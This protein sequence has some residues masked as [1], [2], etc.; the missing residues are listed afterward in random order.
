MP[1]DGRCFFWGLL[2]DS[3]SEEEKTEWRLAERG[4]G[5]PVDASRKHQEDRGLLNIKLLDFSTCRDRLGTIDLVVVQDPAQEQRLQAFV[6]SK[7]NL[8]TQCKT[9]FLNS[10]TP[11]A[12]PAN[13]G[14]GT[15][16]MKRAKMRTCKKLLPMGVSLLVPRKLWQ[17]LSLRFTASSDSIKK[18]SETLMLSTREHPRK[19][20]MLLMVDHLS[21]QDSASLS[22]AGQQAVTDLLF[23]RGDL[24]LMGV[25]F[26]HHA[27]T[28]SELTVEEVIEMRRIH[29][30][31]GS[32]AAS[33]PN[34]SSQTLENQNPLKLA[35][36]SDIFSFLQKLSLAR[37]TRS[38]PVS[39]WIQDALV[40]AGIRTVK[41]T[42]R[43]IRE[44]LE[45]LA[46][47]Q[48]LHVR[49]KCGERWDPTNWIVELPS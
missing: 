17:P 3:L 45:S 35:K 21:A 25:I 42:H 6:H 30:T 37:K 41:D 49:K 47:S 8:N 14:D 36:A 39:S 20:H 1:P 38:L 9:A 44:A 5:W 48:R 11:C 31:C 33:H 26:S 46:K 10:R 18:V 15:I 7:L 16:L 2:V 27:G 34:C 19:L 43:H 12:W 28:W 13:R 29:D 40:A 22:A 23:Q 4:N 32:Q 24:S